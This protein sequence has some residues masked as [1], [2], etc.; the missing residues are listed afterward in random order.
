MGAAAADHSCT[1]QTLGP[2]AVR[3]G[4]HPEHTELFI[5]LCVTVAM[6]AA[7]GVT[8]GTS[9]PIVFLFPIGVVMN[10]VRAGPASVVLCSLV[11]AAVFLLAS[12]L[13][14]AG[15]VLSHPLQMVSVGVMQLAVTIAAVALASAEISHRRA[16]I[17]DP[18]TGLL[19][20]QGLPDRFE[21]LRQQALVS[22]APITLVLFDLDHFKRVNDLHGHDVGDR[23][24]REVAQVIR[25]TLRRF[26]LVYRMGGEEF[27]LL[28][29]GMAESEGEEVAEELRQA[30]SRGELGAGLG[31]TASFGVSGT[32][33]AEVDFDRLHRRAD[34]ALYRAKRDGRDRVHISGSRAPAPA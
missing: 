25:G 4:A 11:T 6:A 23:L 7:A 3:S 20:R 8:G 24:L 27:L 19:N 9:S 32:D 5:S 16:S 21:E 18:L 22:A 28:L 33:S 29:P 26:E 10:A 12:L 17:V 14:D 30:I 15:A 34:Q 1:R 13:N 31:V 2:L